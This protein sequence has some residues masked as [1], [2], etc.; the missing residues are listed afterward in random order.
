[1]TV[2]DPVLGGGWPAFYS[3]YSYPYGR[4][5]QNAMAATGWQCPGCGH[6]YG[7]SVA[8]CWICPQQATATTVTSTVTMHPCPSPLEGGMCGCEEAGEP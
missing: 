4:G 7:P 8:S 3:A 6:C 1:M 2:T 5:E